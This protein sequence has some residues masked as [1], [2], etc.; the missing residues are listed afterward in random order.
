M[1]RMYTYM[2]VHICIH[3]WLTHTRDAENLVDAGISVHET[4]YLNSHGLSRLP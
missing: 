2:C 4:G 3:I 1:Y